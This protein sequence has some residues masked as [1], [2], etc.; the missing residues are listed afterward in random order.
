MLKL[1]T[2]ALIMLLTGLTLNLSEI[3]TIISSLMP[4]NN[5]F[6]NS[7]HHLTIFDVCGKLSMS[8]LQHG[9]QWIM[10]V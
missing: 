5:I 7:S 8:K 6:P 1:S 3:V 4:K 10:R 9:L 2:N